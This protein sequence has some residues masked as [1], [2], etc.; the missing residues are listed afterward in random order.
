M[1]N[2]I[3]KL[4]SYQIIT[5]LL[6]GAFF[7][8][9]LRFFFELSLPTE[10]I[11]EEI[12]IYYFMGLVIN[13]LGSLVVKPILEKLKFINEATYCDYLKAVSQDKELNILSQTNNYFRSILTSLLL[14]PIIGAMKELIINV[15]WISMNWKGCLIGVFI[16]IFLFAFRKQTCFVK[17]RIEAINNLKSE[18]LTK[19]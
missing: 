18:T 10:N 3:E 11:G 9:F 2:I 13:R 1:N 16:G 17:G 14:L 12:L 19:T 7:G 5:N 15:N 4:D 6:P 8:V